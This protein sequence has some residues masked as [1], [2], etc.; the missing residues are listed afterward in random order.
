MGAPGAVLVL[1]EDLNLRVSLAQIL[2]QAGYVVSTACSPCDARTQL[3][4]QP[5]GLVFVDIGLM[6]GVEMDLVTELEH[7]YPRTP[8]LVL[9]PYLNSDEKMSEY[10]NSTVHFLVKPVDPTIILELIRSIMLG[11]NR[12][13]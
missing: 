9:S 10:Q 2:K 8:L 4:A 7:S 6:A 5:F 11:K 13:S 1:D 3:A 12:P